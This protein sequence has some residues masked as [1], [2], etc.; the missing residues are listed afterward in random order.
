MGFGL[1]LVLIWTD[2]DEYGLAKLAASFLVLGIAA[3]YVS[4]VALAV[5]NQKFFNRV[6][7]EL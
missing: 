2:F 3:A 1:F 6:G 7:N 5:I 4:L